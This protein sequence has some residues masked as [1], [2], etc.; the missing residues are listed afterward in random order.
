MV[1]WNKSAPPPFW[2]K[3]ALIPYTNICISQILF[4]GALSGKQSR[5][6]FFNVQVI[7]S[8]PP[9]VSVKIDPRTAVDACSL[10]VALSN[11]DF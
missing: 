5:S 9:G 2:T 10:G 7:A 4:W 6:M 1:Q 3:F 8:E 11:T